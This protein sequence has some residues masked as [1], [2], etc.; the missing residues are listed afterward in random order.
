MT[1][2]NNKSRSKNKKSKKK[3][4]K[5]ENKKSHVLRF[6][7]DSLS[8][9]TFDSINI[10]ISGAVEDVCHSAEQGFGFLSEQLRCF[11]PNLRR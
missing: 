6:H 7:T 3:S 1:K 11:P 5:T 8:D 9:Q 4:K 2:E 10:A